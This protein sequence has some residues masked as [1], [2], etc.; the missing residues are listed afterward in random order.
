MTADD[1][2]TDTLGFT[3]LG[4]SDRKETISRIKT[5]VRELGRRHPGVFEDEPI[6]V[7]DYQR[8]LEDAVFSLG[9]ILRQEHGA[10]NE[11]TVK[12]VFLEP[13][14]DANRLTFEDQ[15]SGE[16]IDFK[17]RL[18][19]TGER[20]AMDVKGGEGQSIGHL[21]APEN[22]DFLVLWSE[23]NARNTKRPPSRLNEVINRS[24][25]WGFNQ[26]EDVAM[27][28]VRDEP[29]GARTDN[30]TVIPDV[31]VFPERFPTPSDPEPPMRELD[32]LRFAEI[33][34]GTLIEN[35]DLHSEEVRKHL[36]FHELRLEEAEHGFT[37][38]KELYN[39]FDEDIELWTQSID[40]DRISEVE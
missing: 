13:A 9:G 6:T 35:D 38:E 39:A 22:A 1:P 2:W 4:T 29:A 3:D 5:L 40:Y 23:R 31:V 19:T 32:E 21:L 30:G 27:M 28:V 26:D 17:G 10:A 11:D 25:R 36:W 24:V 33:L 7:A 37:V 15:R 8:E 14:R 16:R 18:T 12:S 20:F 34:Y